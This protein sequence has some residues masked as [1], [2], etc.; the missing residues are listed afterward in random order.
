MGDDE[1]HLFPSNKEK[2]T[3]KFD[4]IID[5]KTHLDLFT[6]K[7]KSDGVMYIRPQYKHFDYNVRSVQ[8]NK[9]NDITMSELIEVVQLSA[10]LGKRDE[11]VYFTINLIN[12]PNLL[13]KADNNINDNEISLIIS[14]DTEGTFE[15]GAIKVNQIFTGSIN[16][17]KYRL[18]ELGILLNTTYFGTQLKIVEIIRDKYMAYEQ[19]K[20]KPN[21]GLTSYNCYFIL[22]KNNKNFSITIEN[23]NGKNISYG[24]IKSALN[25]ANYILLP[26]DYQNKKTTIKISEYNFKLQIDNT[27][28]NNTDSSN[29]YILFLFSVENKEDLYYKLNVIL[30]EEKPES[31]NNTTKIIIIVVILVVVVLIVVGIILFNVISKRR[32]NRASTEIEKLESLD[33]AE[34]QLT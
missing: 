6:I 9:P 10:P 4:E 33:S 1:N 23:L 25:D 7:C 21:D 30:T 28:Y 5:L 20:E 29:P 3:K 8:E 34:N 19:L 13:L 31:N 11:T 27:Y 16:L 17:A 2:Y 14:P 26:D 22:P 18:D 12:T 32:K 15:K 24:I